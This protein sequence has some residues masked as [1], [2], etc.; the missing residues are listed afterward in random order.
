[1]KQNVATIDRVVRAIA[2]ITLI[3]IY[4]LEKAA[5]ITGSS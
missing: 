2:G 3:A 5:G 1:M 4:T